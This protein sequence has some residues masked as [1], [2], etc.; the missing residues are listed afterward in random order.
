MQFRI[1]VEQQRR[2]F[3]PQFGNRPGEL[4]FILPI[5]CSNGEA[6]NRRQDLDLDFQFGAAAGAGQSFTGG[7]FVEPP[8]RHRLACPGVIQ[9]GLRLAAQRENAAH[10]RVAAILPVQHCA[11]FDLARQNAR[12]A[13]LTAMRGVI[14]FQDLNNRII[15]RD[16]ETRPHSGYV[17]RFVAERFEQPA[18]AIVAGRRPDEHGND[19]ALLQIALQVVEDFVARR[20][21]IR[22]QLLH[23]M[24]VVIRELLQHLVAGF[25]F[26]SFRLVVHVDQLRSGVL[27]IDICALQREIDESCDDPVFPNRDLPQ[28][29]R[30]GRDLLQNCQSLAQRCIG[31]VDFVH[32]QRMR[33]VQIGEPLQIRLQHRRLRGLRFADYNSGVDRRQNVKRL[34]QKFN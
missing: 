22:E 27:A 28:H 25:A 24:L 9:F 7:D 3:L 14:G 16:T 33:D 23:E 15:A 6:I 11:V 1:L 21:Y 5:R 18:Y 30:L 26:A 4:H 20:R 12:Q 13:E 32:K 2:I 34:L 19:Q 10:A 29:Q 31:L 8:Q 17:G